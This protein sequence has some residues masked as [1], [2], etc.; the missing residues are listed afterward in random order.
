MKIKAI[1]IAREL[2]ISKATV[3]L[4]LNNKPGVSE[5]TKQDILE[6][7]VRMQNGIKTTD[8]SR[9]VRNKQMIKIIVVSKNL[10]IVRNSELDLWTDV[11]AVFDRMAKKEGYT[12]GISYPDLHTDSIEAVVMECNV[13]T[14][15]G[16]VL[17]GTELEPSDIKYFRG[18]RK[19][20]VIYDSDMQCDKYPYVVV[21][22][23]V[24][25]HT[26]VDYLVKNEHKDIVYLANSIDIYNYLERRKGFAEAIRSHN[27]IFDKHSIA[28]VGD[29]IET[30]YQNMKKYL[31]IHELPSA[32]VM[33]SYHISVGAIRAFRE[34]GIIIPEDISLI[35]I[36]ELPS[37]MTGECQMTTI[38]IPHTERAVWV[39]MMLFKEITDSSDVKSR[40]FT[41]CKLI[42][43]NSVKL[44]ILK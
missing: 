5:Q 31:D 1:D 29:R 18:I 7:M 37:Y 15:A 24:G 28:V 39:M 35:G 25:V 19:P 27:L 3:S 13:D 6:C 41:N 11:N 8:D 16:I 23:R 20:M 42:E 14:V 10:K 36:D 30:V 26:A 40:M 34:R 22:N 2:G 43:G 12:L 44:S 17:F 38:R 33:E 4:A 32:F 21:N 9:I